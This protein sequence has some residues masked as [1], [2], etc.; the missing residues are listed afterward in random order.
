MVVVAFCLEERTGCAV[1]M[2][3]SLEELAYGV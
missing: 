2:S 1:D 3:G